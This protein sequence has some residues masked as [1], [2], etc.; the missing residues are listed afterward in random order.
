[1]RS[2]LM[3]TIDLLYNT[4]EYFPDVNTRVATLEVTECD[5][6]GF[7]DEV[8][9]LGRL[10]AIVCGDCHIG[11]QILTRPDITRE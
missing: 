4:N 3:Q 5:K 10:S 2:Y 7:E 9:G 6:L 8:A 1:V 11:L